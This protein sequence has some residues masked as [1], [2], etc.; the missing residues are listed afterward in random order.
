MESKRKDGRK[1]AEIEKQYHFDVEWEMMMKNGKR[2][3]DFF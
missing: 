2:Q 3:K 1:R